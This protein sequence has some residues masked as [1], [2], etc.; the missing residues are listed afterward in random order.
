MAPLSSFAGLLVPEISE[1]AASHDTE[2][3]ERIISR[4]LKT[5]LIYSIGVAGIMS[6]L[7]TEF[8]KVIISDQSAIKYLILV[9]PLIPVMYLDTSVDSILKGLGH[10]FYCMIINIV[11]ALLSVILVWILLP[12]YGI[13]GY[14]V[15]VYFTELINATLSITKLLCVTKVKFKI[16]EWV[17]K[18]IIS[19]IASTAITRYI[20]Y[21]LNSF[22]QNKFEIT[23]HIIFIAVIY[24]LLLLLTRAISAKKIKRSIRNFIKA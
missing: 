13:I 6:C 3:I 20:L 8:G 21:K 22:A 19:I 17:G 11:D 9:A 7:S 2:R 16:F 23:V 5:V 10:Q 1:S 15:T 12:R 24:I 14:I 18:P 4:V